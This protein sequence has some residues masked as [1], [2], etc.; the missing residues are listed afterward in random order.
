LESKPNTTLCSTARTEEQQNRRAN[1][2]ATAEKAIDVIF[3]VPVVSF[4]ASTE[5]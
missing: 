5:P 3:M 1:K 2:S 4:G